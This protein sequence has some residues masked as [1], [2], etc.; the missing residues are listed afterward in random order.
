MSATGNV[1]SFEV[2][3]DDLVRI[4]P[5]DY[6]VMYVRH[7]GVRV[8][9][10][11][12]IRVDFRLLAHPDLIVSRWYRV[13]NFHRGRVRAGPHSDIVRELSAVLGRR[14][15]HDRI[16]VSALENRVVLASVRDVVEDRKQ[17]ALAPVNRYSVISRL[18]E[19]Q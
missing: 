6:L 5:G 7:I 13:I 19:G 12:K 10:T 1:I 3:T 14:V 17:D 9:M 11:A 8:F 16:P 18:V 15:R 2:A 4:G